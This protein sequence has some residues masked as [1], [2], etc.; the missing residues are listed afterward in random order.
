MINRNAR[1]SLIR[2]PRH[3]AAALAAA[4]FLI[5]SMT[6]AQASTSFPDKPLRIIVP[7]APGGASDQLAR[8]MGQKLGERLGQSV[9]VENKPGAG[10]IIG[11]E[12]AARSAGDGYTLL[13]AA[14]GFMAVNPAVYPKLPYDP[15][16]DFQPITLLV[17]APLL[18]VANP[19]LPVKDT[20]EF[21]AY[22][23][24]NPGK[25][26]IGNGGVGT[27]QHLGGVYFAKTAGIEVVHVPYKGSAP[28]TTDL[29]GG[30]VDA[31]FDNMVTLIPYIK[32]GKLRPLGVAAMTGVDALPD[33]PTMSNNG[34][35]GFETGT[36]YGIVAPAS[37]PPAVVSKLDLELQQILQLPDVKEKLLTQGLL[38]SGMNAAGF[39]E[40]INSEIAIY[41][42]IVKEAGVTVD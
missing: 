31:Q 21:I 42:K 24:A 26:T 16:K 34:L 20:K 29:I 38:P 7:F 10:G 19:S 22:A 14:A 5:A 37:T 1:N 41:G 23:K 30:T 33:T 32:T 25:V 3:A 35:P 28:A 13:L 36:W 4:S 9:I 8:I 27:A 12:T 39:G 6:G 2:L 17:K 15:V 11:A 40:F 18:L